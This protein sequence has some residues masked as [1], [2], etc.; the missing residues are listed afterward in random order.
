MEF[1]DEQDDFSVAF[2]DFLKDRFQA[3]FKF[4]AIFG[5][6]HKRSEIKTENRLVF[7]AFRDIAFD[8]PLRE[9]LR[10]RG[11]SDTRLTDQD[12]VIFRFARKNANDSP[13]FPVAP[14]DRI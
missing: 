8:D 7:Q 5:A 14:D 9:S 4:T 11:L 1:I 13:D 10:D 2:F 3:L 12:R 6:C